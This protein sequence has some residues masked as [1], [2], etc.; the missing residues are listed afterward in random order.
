MLGT[1]V[2]NQHLALEDLRR[3]RDVERLVGFERAHAPHFLAGAGVEG[4]QAAVPGGQ[5][6]LAFPEADAAVVVPAGAHLAGDGAEIGIELPQQRAGRGVHGPHHVHAAD[7]IHHAIDDERGGHQATIRWQFDHPIGRQPADGGVAY[8][9]ERAEALFAVSATISQPV[10]AAGFVRER[11]IIDHAGH[12]VALGVAR[13]TSRR[14]GSC[15]HHG[16]QSGRSPDV[17][18]PI[19]NAHRSPSSGPT[20]RATIAQPGPWHAIWG[21][22]YESLRFRPQI[23]S[24]LPP[25]GIVSSDAQRPAK[26][27]PTAT[28]QSGATYR[29]NR[30]LAACG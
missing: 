19:I 12:G 7:E 24:G 27:R 4:N 15:E 29:C 17:R 23:S 1:A 16:G 28:R 10:V 9:D 2:A 21:I 5:I 8:L 22:L 20:L 18:R 13:P 6:H 3:A 14:Q 11:R 30:R 25:F 26:G